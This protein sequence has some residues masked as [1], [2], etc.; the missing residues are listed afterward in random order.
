MNK[1]IENL[2]SKFHSLPYLANMGAKK[3]AKKEGME[4]EDVYEARALYRGKKNKFIEE[5]CAEAGID[6]SQVKSFW[7]RDKTTS[8]QVKNNSE[9]NLKEEITDAFDELLSKYQSE[10]VKE[11]KPKKIDEPKALKVTLS[12]EHIGM[13]PSPNAAGSLFQYEYNSEI[14]VNSLQDVYSSILKEFNTHGTFE[15]LLLDDLGD[16]EDGWDGNTTRGG[17][18]LEQNMTNAEIFDVCVDSKIRLIESLVNAQVANKIILRTVTNS[19][20]SNDFA[21]IVNKAIEKIINRIYSTKIVEVE[22]LERFIEH[23][24][25]GNHTWLLCHG[26][27]A[28]FQFKG[29]PLIL[30]D[31]TTNF[32]NEYIKFYNIDGKYI[33]FEKGDLHQLGY[34]KTINFD[35]RNYMSFAP[36]SAWQQH[37]F[38]DA[39]AGYS[40]QV[41]PKYSNQISHTDYFLDYRKA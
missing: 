26:K 15:L 25:W 11:F 41:I 10:G 21:L 35:Y 30:N 18:G 32:I 29:L 13:N 31:K 17:H 2:V 19:N 28:K 23:R 7:F 24:S 5:K 3:I 33:H 4:L 37:N 1:N 14:Y 16:R 40:I 27:D 12:D 34:Q 22:V 36:P 20:H 38:G 39:Y 9:S 8:I 6:A